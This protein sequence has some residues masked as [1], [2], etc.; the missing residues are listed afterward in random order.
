[1]PDS[2]PPLSRT[3]SV[4]CA[5][6]GCALLAGACACAFLLRLGG[7]AQHVSVAVLLLL[8]AALALFLLGRAKLPA[9]WLGA[10]LLPIGL[11]IVLRVLCL[12]HVTYDYRDFLSQWAAFFRDNGGFAA[13]KQP[14]G[15]YNVPYLYFMAAISYLP[16]PDLYAIKLFSILFDVILAWGGL[17]L[18]QALTGRRDGPAGPLVFLALFLLP[19]VVL[20]GSF[21]GQCD[22]LYGALV[23]HALACVPDGRPKT[24][25]ALLAV[26][27]SFKLQTIF[28]IPLWGALWLAGRVKFTHL[29][30]FPAAYGATVLPALLL[31]KPLG[32]IL[33]VYFNQAGQYT[34]ALTFNAPSVFAF[35]PYGAEVDQAFWSRAGILTAF[36]LCLFVL[37]WA[38]RRRDTLDRDDMMA[39]AAVL[40]L[41]VPFFLPYM[42]ERYLFLADVITLVW[43]FRDKRRIPIAALTELSSLSSY[44]VYLR[45]RYTL[46]LHFAGHIWT[47]ALEAMFILAALVLSLRVLIKPGKKHA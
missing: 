21:W 32:D 38:R 16:V 27:F 8:Y 25:V 3:V 18:T 23:L 41:G 19:T 35:L 28:L 37:A 36:V 33:S 9:S 31:G 7:L 34:T 11:A 47:M 10:A 17:R 30:V 22:S 39:A 6:V 12:D 43:A 29:L 20:N 13:I 2:F 5:A 1:M 24:S 46:P 42:H 14:I 26:A 45:L 40:A 4:I 44:C 15:D